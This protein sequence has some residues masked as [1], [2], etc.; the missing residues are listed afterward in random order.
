MLKNPTA[1]QQLSQHGFHRFARINPGHRRHGMHPQPS[2]VQLQGDV[3][4]LRRLLGNSM[5]LPQDGLQKCVSSGLIIVKAE[6]SI[7]LRHPGL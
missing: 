2:H 5:E 6:H 3:S 7:E 1:K 4:L